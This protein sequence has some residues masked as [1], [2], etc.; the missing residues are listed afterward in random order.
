MLRR[1]KAFWDKWAKWKARAFFIEDKVSGTS[2]GQ[3]LIEQGI[4]AVLWKPQDYYFPE[5]KVGRVMH[6]TWYIEAGRVRLPFEKKAIYRR[7]IEECAAF[8]GDDSVN[9]DVVDA[10]TM[11]LSV[12]TYKGGGHDVKAG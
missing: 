6:S 5:D 9:D 12:W 10:L 3:T 11:A 7:I 2:L 8:N 1:A 4:P